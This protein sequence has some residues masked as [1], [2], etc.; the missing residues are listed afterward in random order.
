MR[1]IH[2]ERKSKKRVIIIVA[3]AVIVLLLAAVQLIVLYLY[4]QTFHER[5]SSESN[6]SILRFEDYETLNRERVDFK[7]NKGQNLVGYF[8]SAKAIAEP[9]AVV[10]FNHGFGGG[11]HAYYLPQIEYLAQHGYMVLGFDKTGNDESDG[12]YVKGL[13]QGV[14]DLE[15]AL[16]FVRDDERSKELPILLYGHSW[17]GYSV[18]SVLEKA[19]DIKAVVSISSFNKSQDML[20]E[21]GSQMYGSITKILSPFMMLCDIFNF[22]SDAFVSSEKGLAKTEAEVLIVHSDDDNIIDINGSFNVYK[23]ELSDKPNLHFIELTGKQHEPFFSTECISYNRER[24]E[25]RRQYLK[26][27]PNISDDEL[28]E[29]LLNR[30]D[31]TRANELD[32]DLMAQIA[33][34]YDN[35]LNGEK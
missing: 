14:I 3:V 32:Q 10:V 27:N 33:E 24:S 20:M 6:N 17:G 28:K 22:G 31:R 1:K 7:S 5:F 2:Q 25:F 4:N 34:F 16:D 30:F 19:D 9:E 11:G 35:A 29:V 13:P 12:K 21:Q 23:N 26:E 18:C 15:Y 8:Y